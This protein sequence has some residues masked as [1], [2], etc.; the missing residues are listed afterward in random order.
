MSM[1]GY[2]RRFFLSLTIGSAIAM[3][4]A[5]SVL[6]QKQTGAA[7]SD[8]FVGE[9][10]LDLTKSAFIPGPGPATRNMNISAVDNGL[11][12]HL[13][14]SGGFI[15]EQ[16]EYVI[17][18]DGKDHPADPSFDVDNYAVKRVDANTIDRTGKVRGKAVETATFKLSADGKTLTID[19]KGSIN[20]SDYNSTQVFTKL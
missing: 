4:G 14:D 12:I 1:F 11:R 9:W 15:D 3:C 19:T 6:A 13:H 7:K 20:G 17:Y 2:P 10:S 5:I 16:S 8:P 18:F